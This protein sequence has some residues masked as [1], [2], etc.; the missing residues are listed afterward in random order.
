MTKKLVCAGVVVALTIVSFFHFRQP[1]IPEPTYNDDR[2][3][4]WCFLW[5]LA[6]HS[7]NVASR[8]LA[9]KAIRSI[10]TNAMPFILAKVTA[11][12]SYAQVRAADL[13]E[14]VPRYGPLLHDKLLEFYQ[15][16]DNVYGFF[17][18]MGSE[19]RAAIP[20]LTTIVNKPD[21]QSARLAMACLFAIGDEAFPVIENVISN[22]ENPAIGHVVDC[23]KLGTP[24][25]TRK[26]ELLA[27][28]IKLSNSTNV[29]LARTAVVA[30]GSFSSK[31]DIVVPVLTNTLL[32]AEPN[33]GIAAIEALIQLRE[34]NSIT[35]ALL[36]PNEQVRAAATN[37]L[38]PFEGAG[39]LPRL[40]E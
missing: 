39:L 10:G 7:K 30:L 38:H 12:P 2:L 26:D 25:L 23:V 14:E 8:D 17:M 20:T 35:P 28:I 36:H 4:Q 32:S 24:N 18:V 5:S 27:P 11:E 40:S 9:E 6:D 1:T 33:V 37:A 15:D 34:T 29:S 22:P 16:K 31:K 3:L 13:C 21:N 19:S